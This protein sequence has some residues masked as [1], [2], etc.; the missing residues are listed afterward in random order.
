CKSSGTFKSKS[1]LPPMPASIIV[2]NLQ[3][4]EVLSYPLVLLQGRITD[5]HPSAN[6]FLDARLDDLRPC[7]WPISPTGH[8][9]AFVLLPSSGKFA[10]TLQLSGIARRIFCVEY[11]PRVTRFVVKFHYQICSDADTRDGF[12]APLGVD[13]SDTVAIAKIRFNALILQMATAELMHAAGLPRLTFAMQFAPD[14]LPDVT[15]LRCRF[16]NAHARSVDGQKL[17][18]LVQQDIE[19]AGWDDHPELDFKHAVV[20]GCSRYN[21][22]ARKAEG[23]TALGGGK[24]GVFG[25]CGLHT[26]P[27]HL[28]ELSLCCLNNTRIDTR[29]LLDDSCY[30]GTF[31]ANFST[32]IGAMLHEI[33]HTFGL[34]H[35]TRGIMAR[36]FDD[37]NRLLCVYA[38]DPRSSQQSFRRSTAQ[39]WLDLNHTVVREVTSRGGAHWNSASAQLLRHSP[40]ISGYAKPSLVG[41]TV[42]WGSSVLGPVGHGTYNG[43]QIDLPE[44]TLSSSV[45]DELGAVMIDADKYIDHFET[46]TRAQVAEAERTEPLRAAGSKHWFILA[47][48]EYITRVDVRAMAWIDG[49]QLHT[50]LRSSRWYGGT[51]GNLHALKPAEGWHVSSFIGSRGDSHVGRLGVRCLPTSSVSSRPLSLESNGT[52]NTVLSFPPAGKALEGN[53]KTPFSITLTEIGAV[54][55]QCGRFVEGVKLL[56]PE[57]AVSNSRDPRFYRSNEHVFQLCPGEKLIKLEVF[58]GHWVDCIRFTTTLRASPWFGG[59]RGPNHTVMEGPAGHHICGLHGIRGKQYVGSVGALY[60]ADAAATCLQTQH[61]EPVREMEDQPKTRKFWVMRTVPVSNQIA[62][63]PKPPLGILIAVQNGSVTSVQSFDSVEMFDELVTQLHS[64]LLTVGT[65][66]QVH[67]VPLRPG[68]KVLQIDVSFR[69]ASAD[70]PYTVIDGVCFHTTLRCSSWFGAYR[71]SNLR[72]F[73]PPADTSVIRVQGTYTDSILTDL[74]GVIG[75]SINSATLFTPDARVLVDDGAYDV[76]L[77]AAT[78]EFGVESVLLVKKNNGDNLDKHAWTWNQHGMPYPRAWRVPHT[79][80]EAYV[81]SKSALYEEYLV[82]AINSGGAFS[83]TAAPVLRQ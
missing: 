5:L 73:M 23:H 38:A 82:G 60:C 53:P 66:Y 29:Y 8:F 26:W 3:E 27:S 35:A 48:G 20:L 71:E 11:R 69:P 39:G 4:D 7:L 78:P 21:R 30:R 55:V 1:N 63:P 15:L 42:D 62:D 2:D 68:E 83:K 44:K 58:S 76:R 49:L 80:L 64:T 25:S 47:D 34:G 6:L 46:L 22:E 40:W 67:C 79:M 18:K 56:T 16:T 13:N 33:G 54:V 81:D 9:K 77:E 36:G 10:I 32:G 19:A 14:G 51:G 45:D 52:T 75:V 31:W 57:E 28:G 24:V 70:D 65:S 41:P 43:T 12:D 17:I 74:T 72:F 37:M 50:N 59:G 61:Q